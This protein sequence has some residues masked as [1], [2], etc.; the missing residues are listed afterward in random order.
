MTETQEKIKPDVEEIQPEESVRFPQPSS[1]PADPLN[2]A[3]WRKAALLGVSSLYAFVSNFN[4][5]VMSSSL[6]LWSKTFPHDPRSFPQLPYL[7]GANVLFL[8][9]SNIL[10]VPLSNI[11]GRRPAIYTIFLCAGSLV[12][13]IS[14][15]YI[16]YD[17]GWAYPY[18][19]SLA[20]TGTT[21]LGHVFLLPE[22]LYTRE[23]DPAD[24]ADSTKNDIVHQEHVQVVAPEHDNNHRPYTFIRSLGFIQPPG[25]VVRSFLKPWRTLKL[26]GTWVVMSHY[27]GLVGGIVTI[28]TLSPQILAMPPYQWGSNVGLISIGALVG[29]VL[30]AAYTYAVSDMWLKR[31][32]KH[33]RHGFAE[34]EDRLP[35]MFPALC[36]ATCGFF[37]FGFTG[38][39]AGAK[40]WVGMQVGFGMVS[41]GLMQVPSIGFNY[42]ID[43]YSAAAA[44]CFVMVTS[45]R[46]ILAFTWTLVVGDWYADRGLA[47]P[48]GIFGMLMGIFS[49]LTVPLWLYGKR[50]RIATASSLE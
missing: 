22:T 7:V 41:F 12:G 44:D 38:P 29:T 42:L 37:V 40:G 13:G 20:L 43:A 30:G 24:S 36:V 4:S 33:R 50:I 8:G 19:V 45:L 32:A 23:S 16:A 31:Q 11:L 49:L 17:Y 25:G 46:A 35:L 9:L 27:G 1:D 28:S 34:A 39:N 15:G 21:F 47:E 3:L 48:F 10:W 6:Q 2:W 18:W 26:P 14:G 5:A